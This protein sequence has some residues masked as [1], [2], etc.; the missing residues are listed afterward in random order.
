MTKRGQPARRTPAAGQQPGP[1][2]G[3]RARPAARASR[4]ERRGA[5]RELELVDAGSVDPQRTS[6]RRTAVVALAAACVLAIVVIGSLDRAG[7]SDRILSMSGDVE[8]VLP[9]RVGGRRVGR[10]GGARRFDPAPRTAGRGRGRRDHGLGCGQLPRD[11]RRADIA[12]DVEPSGVDVTGQPLAPDAR[13]PSQSRSRRSPP[14]GSDRPDPATTAVR[15]TT[16]QAR[17]GD[18]RR[19]ADDDGARHGDDRRPA[20]DLANVSRRHPPAGSLE[21]RPTAPPSPS[22]TSRPD[23]DPATFGHGDADRPVRHRST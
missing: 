11:P 19:P 23:D 3:S 4:V 15:P 16:T 12:D 8:V 14:S 13:P 5:P 10:D 20:A 22:T 6:R 18:H 2:V 21:P 17:T 9:G 1:G 7:S